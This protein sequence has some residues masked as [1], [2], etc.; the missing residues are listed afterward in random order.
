MVLAENEVE[1]EDGVP[2]TRFE[3]AL[4]LE[5]PEATTPRG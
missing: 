3:L 1:A 2:A 5:G 4:Q